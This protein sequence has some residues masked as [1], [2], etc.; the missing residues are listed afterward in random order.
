MKISRMQA[1]IFALIFI[2]GSGLAQEKIAP[3]E[4][5][6]RRQNLMAR[7]ADGIL[8]Q[9]ARNLFANDDALFVHGFQQN[10]SFFYFT[11]LSS[12]VNAILAIDGAAK[13]SWLFVPT[14]L[15]GLEKL[16]PQALIPPGRETETKLLLEHVVPWE[17]F[18][19]F[20]DRKQQQSQ[21]ILYVD[22]S[23]WVPPPPSNPSGIAPI[24]DTPLLWRNALSSRWPNA[25]IRSAR[26]AIRAL[27]VIKSPAEIDAIRRVAEVSA[28]ALLAG[29][30][31]LQPG[32]SQRQVEAEVVCG[33]IRAGGEG[34]S[35]WPWIMSG[36]NAVIPKPFES[37]VDYRHLNRL[38]QAGELVRVDVGCDVDFYKGDVGRTAPV[39]GRFSPEQR[40]TWNL[41][42]NVYRAG[43]AVMRDGTRHEDVMSACRRE[44][45]RQQPG[46]KTSLEKAAAKVLLDPNNRDTWHLHTSGLEPGEKFPGVLRA[47]M[48]I[49]FEP[50]FAVEGQAFYLEDMILITAAG[51]EILTKSLPYT[52]D[53]IESAIAAHS[54]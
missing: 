4:F 1:L 36:P 39:S 40:E 11:G 47:G 22:N 35:F 31:A 10:P 7:L 25:E 45:E 38:M 20:I 51:C 32:K 19:S 17:E 12:A 30:R 24:S 52:A 46:L 15:P 34:P 26:E 53:E 3:E 28:A 5:H 42:I 29:L 13:E 37:L 48:V 41:L 23:Y 44:A 2:A 6:Q 27:R 54:R 21:L 49:E 16:L 18:T 14:S 43:L 33:C 9:H 8:L 50:M